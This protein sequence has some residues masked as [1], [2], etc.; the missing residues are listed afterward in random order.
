MLR[1]THYG[2]MRSL[3]A[4]LLGLSVAACGPTSV[5]TASP[6]STPTVAPATASPTPSP[7]TTTAATFA[8]VCGTISDFVSDSGVANGSFVLNSPGRD[9]YK[10]TI[11]A[12]RLGGVAANYVCAGVLAGIPRPLFAG[13]VPGGVENFIPSG[14][15]P[16]TLASPGPTGFVLPQAC[17]YAA[18]P[19]V[20]TVQT[21]WSIDCGG[22]NNN[23]RGALGPAFTQQ[24]WS[25]CGAGLG[26]ERWRKNDVV[27][28][29]SESSLAPGGYPRIAQVGRA[30][31]SCF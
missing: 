30:G 13:F 11:P 3:A 20:G 7:A 12:G 4:T 31:S 25:S 23:A 2:R 29:V 16:A 14:T 26:T 9:P 17:A 27:L 1:A 5:S 21:E 6:T 19:I 22:A 15:F 8:F 18:A 28:S 24:G 10:I